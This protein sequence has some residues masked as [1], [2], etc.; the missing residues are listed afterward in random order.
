MSIANKARSKSKKD[1]K[2]RNKIRLIKQAVTQA[3]RDEQEVKITVQEVGDLLRLCSSQTVNIGISLKPYLPIITK[4]E[5]IA[6]T[7]PW[8]VLVNDLKPL[9]AAYDKVLLEAQQYR[10]SVVLPKSGKSNT[11]FDGDSTLSG[12]GLFGEC[13]RILD[14]ANMVIVPLILDCQSQIDFLIKKYGAGELDKIDD[15]TMDV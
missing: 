8:G 15:E 2:Q 11:N 13:N 9:V 10:Q 5:N 1:S 14:E 12:F 7:K 4:E 6:C 3:A